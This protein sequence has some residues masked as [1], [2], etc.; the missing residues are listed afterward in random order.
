[1]KHL[2]GPTGNTLQMS[3][4]KMSSQVHNRVMAIIPARGGSQRVQNKNIRLL[5]GKPLI[6]YTIECALK[7]TKIDRIIVSTDDIEIANTAKK[8]GAEVPFL[9]PI[10]IAGSLSTELEFVDHCLN[11]LKANEN[12]IPELIITLFPTSPFRTPASID[13]AIELIESDPDADALRSVNLCGEHPYK[14]WNAKG[15]YL[16]PLI[17][18]EDSNVHSWSYQKLPKIYIQ[19]ACIYIIKTESVLKKRTTV[20]DKILSFPMEEEEA[21]DINTEYDFSLA[22]KRLLHS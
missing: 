5:A 17:F 2:N 7:T 10:E 18:T 9:R 22:E 3:L 1:M 4:Q 15:K 19:N 11:F 14:M 21:F 20:G 6:T 13:R 8:A 16:E 12:E